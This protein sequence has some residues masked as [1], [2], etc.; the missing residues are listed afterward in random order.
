MDKAGVLSRPPEA[1]G[2]GQRALDDRARVHISA[3]LKCCRLDSSDAPLQS[4][5]PLLEYLVIIA[6][7]PMLLGIVAACPGVASDPACAGFRGLNGEGLRA[8]ISGKTDDG[9]TGPWKWSRHP[10]SQQ[11]SVFVSPLEIS[12]GAGFARAYPLFKPGCV[13]LVGAVRERDKACLSETCLQRPGARLD[14]TQAG[15]WTVRGSGKRI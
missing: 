9:R 2:N 7:A 10:C 8:L 12:H 1:G 13:A 4:F 11:L 14:K 15:A 5:Q 6:G 3:R